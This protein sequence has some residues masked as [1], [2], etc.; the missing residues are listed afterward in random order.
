MTV[1]TVHLQETATEYNLILVKDGFSFMAAV[2]GF[3][4]A[5]VVGAWQLALAL[6]LLQLALSAILPSLIE[7]MVALGVVQFGAA[8]LI[9]MI[10]NEGRRLVLS[11]RGFDEIGVVTG[12]NKVDAERRFLD[13]HPYVTTQLLESS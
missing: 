8:V 1:F 4:W 11:W 5:L 3:I 13:T 2:F 6:L 10:A 7:N 9:G 12:F